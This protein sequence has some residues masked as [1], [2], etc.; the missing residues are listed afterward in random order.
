[1]KRYI[2][3]ATFNL[4][5]YQKY[6][7]ILTEHEFEEEFGNE[8][9]DEDGDVYSPA[10]NCEGYGEVFNRGFLVAKDEYFDALADAGIDEAELVSIDGVIKVVYVAGDRLIPLT[11]SEIERATG[12]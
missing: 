2:K 9:L 5:P 4:I 1:M 8:V 3:S 11:I 10:E 7:R 12:M 6:Y